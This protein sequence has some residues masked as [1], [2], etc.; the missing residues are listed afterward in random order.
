MDTLCFRT[1]VT[2]ATAAISYMLGAAIHGSPYTPVVYDGGLA[3]NYWLRFPSAPVPF[4]AGIPTAFDFGVL[5][6]AASRFNGSTYAPPDIIPTV[7]V[8]SVVVT[9]TE[10]AT[11]THLETTTETVT[12][13]TAENKNAPSPTGSHIPGRR[14]KDEHPAPIQRFLDW[15]KSYPLLDLVL[16]LYVFILEYILSCL[17]TILRY[18]LWAVYCCLFVEGYIWDQWQLVLDRWAVCFLE[19]LKPENRQSLLFPF[20]V[21][22]FGSFFVVYGGIIYYFYPRDHAALIRFV[23]TFCLR[24]SGAQ[25]REGVHGASTNIATS[26][27]G[28]A[29]Q[30]EKSTN[31]KAVQHLVR[32]DAPIDLA[33]SEAIHE[34]ESPDH[35]SYLMY[36]ESSQQDTD[37]DE[38]CPEE[39]FADEELEVSSDTANHPTDDDIP[40]CPSC[41]EAI[42]SE[43]DATVEEGSDDARDPGSEAEE[44]TVAAEA[45]TDSE[46]TP[47]DSTPYSAEQEDVAS[48]SDQDR[49]AD[50]TC[51]SSQTA[52][53]HLSTS[54]RSQYVV[55]APLPPSTLP[56]ITVSIPSLAEGTS[57]T[58]KVTTPRP[59]SSLSFKPGSATLSLFPPPTSSS[60]S[61][62]NPSP[63]VA[64][65]QECTSHKTA[66]SPHVWP[67]HRS[68]KKLLVQSGGW[69]V[70]SNGFAPEVK[71]HRGGKWAQKQKLKEALKAQNELD[72]EQA[73]A[74]RAVAAA[75]A[76]EAVGEDQG[77][78]ADEAGAKPTVAAAEATTQDHDKGTAPQPGSLSI[79]SDEPPQESP[80]VATT[81][82][83]T[84]QT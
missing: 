28:E 56:E 81:T 30:S 59:T 40:I 66:G 18:A 8:P 20:Q 53:D 2:L 17:Y 45:D 77:T 37:N 34:S 42:V 83:E 22:F 35:T 9:V 46:H 68:D 60:P 63:K 58:R 54:P 67:V 82:E 10:T 71:V 62:E 51:E 79:A 80:H 39:Y 15:R 12:R 13:S 72:Q 32:S 1:F 21:A 65:P 36:S 84:P 64:L 49:D 48:A 25:H 41:Q 78:T 43:P 3:T 14:R 44:S 23:D 27:I 50:D 4:P 70:P 47:L 6:R 38:S 57:T 19:S 7:S 76:S 29:Q 31:P 24:L 75:A 73:A 69:L 5:F 11:T 55:Y 16:K 61:N 52:E 33:A 26:N 74:A